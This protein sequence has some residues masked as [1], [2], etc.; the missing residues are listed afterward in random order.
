[1]KYFQPKLQITARTIWVITN[2]LGYAYVKT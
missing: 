2:F 1:V